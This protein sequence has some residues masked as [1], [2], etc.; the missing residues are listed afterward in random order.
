[1]ISHNFSDQT[2][3]WVYP[4]SRTL[5][6]QE[7][8]Y[9]HQQCAKFCTDWTAHNHALKAEAT[10]FESRWLLL[11]VDESL[12]GA[13]GC[14]IDKSVHFLE[15]LGDQLG[16]DFFDRMQFAWVNEAENI[17]FGNLEDMQKAVTNGEITTETKMINSL[18]ASKK[19]FN[20][21]WMVEFG[22][23]WQ[24]RLVSI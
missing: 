10:L 14:S 19:D 18:I 9:I 8:A 3:L 15:R 24:R 20:E 21:K 5:N 4:C 22:K 16:V 11:M 13:S 12:T 2:R 6:E 1:M 23:S 7:I 17:C